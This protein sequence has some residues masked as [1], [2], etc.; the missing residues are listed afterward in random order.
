MKKKKIAF[1]N[2][3][4]VS[5][6]EIQNQ[7]ERKTNDTKYAYKINTENQ[8]KSSNSKDVWNGVKMLSGSKKRKLRLGPPNIHEYVN[9]INSFLC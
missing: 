4:T 9:K 5:G 1:A 7:F 8:F 6:A 2:G 3:D